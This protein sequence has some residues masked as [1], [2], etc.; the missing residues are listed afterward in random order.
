MIT[1]TVERETWTYAVTL[2]CDCEGCENAVTEVLENDQRMP[3]KIVH[4]AEA[5][6]KAKGWRRHMIVPITRIA[7]LEKDGQGNPIKT[8]PVP[9]EWIADRCPDCHKRLSEAAA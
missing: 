5:T 9:S 7:V 2:S 1:T 6:F 8:G 3:P 4:A